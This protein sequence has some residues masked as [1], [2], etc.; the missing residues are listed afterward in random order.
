MQSVDERYGD[1]VVLGC[2]NI[3]FGDDGFGACVAEHLLNG[4]AIPKNVSVIDARTSVR[5]ILFD[6]IVHERRPRKVIIIDAVDVNRVPGEVFTINID[7]LPK[8]KIDHMLGHAPNRNDLAYFH[9]DVDVLKELYITYLPHLS[10]EKII[11]VRSLNTEDAKKLE[12][13]A[14]ENQELKAKLNSKDGDITELRSRLDRFERALQA[15]I[16]PTKKSYAG[17]KPS[18]KLYKGIKI[19]VT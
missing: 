12:R 5:N 11:E 19:R 17:K 10:F 4:E 6:L 8:N 2:G 13:L 9:Y 7:D 3:L 16:S 14:N 15:V 18:G 1:V